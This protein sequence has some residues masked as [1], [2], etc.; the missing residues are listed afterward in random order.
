MSASTQL[1]SSAGKTEMGAKRLT[2]QSPPSG[3]YGQYVDCHPAL[4]VR[5][6]SA[7]G[8]DKTLVPEFH[9]CRFDGIFTEA[10][11]PF[12]VWAFHGALAGE[13]VDDR[14]AVM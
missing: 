13:Q 2:L 1:L 11:L 3:S 10:R 14:L 5:V 8:G 9:C 12:N 4:L 7:A 6:W